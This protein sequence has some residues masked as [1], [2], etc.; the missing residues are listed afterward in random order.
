MENIYC[1][2]PLYYQYN[3]NCVNSFSSKILNLNVGSK[4]GVPSDYKAVMSLKGN[5]VGRTYF[6]S[7]N[8]TQVHKIND[9][10]F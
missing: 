10:N 5:L 7:D 1:L 9:K 6:V 2:L 4:N 8:N 3:Y